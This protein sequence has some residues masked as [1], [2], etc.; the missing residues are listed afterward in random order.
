MNICKLTFVVSCLIPFLF[1]GTWTETTQPDFSDGSFDVG[2]FA[3][4]YDGGTLRFT[5]PFDYNGD[6]VIDIVVSN[7]MSSHSDVFWGSASGYLPANKTSYPGNSKGDW[8]AGDVN[9][10]GYPELLSAQGDNYLI[11]I[12]RGTINGPS[13]TD[14]VNVSLGGWNESCLLADLNRDGWLD[15]IVQR[16]SS[17]GGIFWGGPNG[18]SSN[19]MTILPA[20][21]ISDIRCI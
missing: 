19:W 18:Y 16:Y 12:F 6:G 13:P 14:Y 7:E 4:A 3:S 15:L 8:E 21:C 9:N 17:G 11:R 2:L 5:T 20:S 10:D 1:G